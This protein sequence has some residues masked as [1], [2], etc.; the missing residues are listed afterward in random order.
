MPRTA[1]V[2]AFDGHDVHAEYASILAIG[3]VPQALS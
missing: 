3:M 2:V 1:G